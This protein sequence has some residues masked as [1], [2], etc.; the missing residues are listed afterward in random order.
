MLETKATKTSPIL[1]SKF[2]RSVFGNP[3]PAIVIRV[4][5]ATEPSRGFTDVMIRGTSLAVAAASTIAKP[6]LAI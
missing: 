1:T 4:P 6:T 2:P 3:E 5:P